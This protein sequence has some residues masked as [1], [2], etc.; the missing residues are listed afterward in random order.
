MSAPDP[1]ALGGRENDAPIVVTE[2]VRQLARLFWVVMKELRPGYDLAKS[3]LLSGGGTDPAVCAARA[4]KL[5][6]ALQSAAK[7]QP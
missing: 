6:A 7:S 1:F 3:P 2:T 4:A 5:E